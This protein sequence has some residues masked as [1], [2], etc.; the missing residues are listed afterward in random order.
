M[1]VITVRP[2]ARPVVDFRARTRAQGLSSHPSFFID[3]KIRGFKGRASFQIPSTT[4]AKK[5]GDPI[6]RRHPFESR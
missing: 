5:G 4:R 1:P 6:R 2:P 3:K